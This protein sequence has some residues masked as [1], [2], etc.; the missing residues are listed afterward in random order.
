[1]DTARQRATRQ[2]PPRRAISQGG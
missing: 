2:H 1:M